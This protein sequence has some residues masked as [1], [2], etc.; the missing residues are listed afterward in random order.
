[1]DC[2]P[3]T[4]DKFESDYKLIY[5]HSDTIALSTPH[6]IHSLSLSDTHTLSFSLSLSLGHM[7]TI[8]LYCLSLFCTY[9]FQSFVHI[10]PLTLTTGHQ[11]THP[12]SLSVW[13]TQPLFL[14]LS[15]SL[16]QTTVSLAYPQTLCEAYTFSFKT[17]H[18]LTLSLSI[19]L[20]FSFFPDFNCLTLSSLFLFL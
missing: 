4:L 8:I 19:S 3:T 15:E 10:S 12:L 16:P 9:N 14:T 7:H 6:L 2:K 13:S 18:P 5:S 11:P 20:C 17:K 1:M